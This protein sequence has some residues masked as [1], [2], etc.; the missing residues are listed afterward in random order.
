[1]EKLYCPKC[2]SQ[3]NVRFVEKTETFP[4]KGENVAVQ[5]TVC[6]C[7]SC[8]EEL[9]SPEYDDATLRA[10]YSIYRERHGLLQPSEIKEI[11]E[12]YQVS[13]T[14]F[15]RILG[16]GD[17]TIARYENGSLQDEAIN[18]LILLARNPENFHKLLEKNKNKL[19]ADEINRL[20]K[21]L[22]LA[23][24]YIKWENT[25]FDDFSS[26]FPFDARQAYNVCLT[27]C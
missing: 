16:V 19:S 20:E 8:G 18:N 22:G 25:A 17:K 15:A 27:A 3:Q 26:D 4:V 24:V 23:T 1:M 13:Q 21:Q 9:L 10:A 6:T 2:H 12:Q 7:A 14:S 5:A 11:R